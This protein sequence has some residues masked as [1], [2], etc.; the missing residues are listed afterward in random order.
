MINLKKILLTAGLVFAG[1]VVLWLVGFGTPTD[2]RLTPAA[3]ISGAEAID[4]VKNLSAVRQF[5][6]DL[7]KAGSKAKLNVEDGG[8]TWN[9]QVFEIVEQG[10]NS[11]TATFNWYYVD[12]KT[13]SIINEFNLESK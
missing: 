10:E 12:K 13:G 11:H 2:D 5:V 9:V 3:G 7:D 4:K 6:S 8:D 1:L